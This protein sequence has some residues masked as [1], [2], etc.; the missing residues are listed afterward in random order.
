MKINVKFRQQ[1]YDI[2]STVQELLEEINYLKIQ[3]KSNKNYLKLIFFL[4]TLMLIKKVKLKKKM[5][6]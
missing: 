3:L 4:I 6:V 2:K 5:K 1:F